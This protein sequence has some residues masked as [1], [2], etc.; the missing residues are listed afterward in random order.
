VCEIDRG[1]RSGQWIKPAGTSLAG[2]VAALVGLGDI[3]AHLARR[4]LAAEMRVIGY[5][6][7]VA[8]GS[9]P[10]GVERA[11]WPDHLEDADFVVLACALTPENRHMLDSRILALVKH[12]VRIVNVS[13]GALIDE[14]ALIG[15]L[16][17]GRA[18]AAALDVFETEP[19]PQ[20][21]G[22]RQFP[23]CIFGSHNASNTVE[24]VRRTSERA[25]DVLLSLLGCA[26]AA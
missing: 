26:A 25:I 13:R 7:G 8:P 11:A 2:K 22:L 3:G 19:L 24:A 4:L 5:D 23:Q 20:S 9:E 15:A 21:S 12:G 16:R 1:V 14:E 6:P 17:S 18:A 10:P